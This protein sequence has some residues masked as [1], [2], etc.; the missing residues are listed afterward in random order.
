[1]EPTLV[2]GSVLFIDHFWYKL[3]G[4][5]KKNDIVVAIQPVN[6]ETHICKRVI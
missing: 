1:M 4:G 5:I 3:S 6:P 2:E